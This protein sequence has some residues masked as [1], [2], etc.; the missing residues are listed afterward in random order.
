[1]L[2]L[3]RKRY[4]VRDTDR[5]LKCFEHRL[6][7]GRVANKEAARILISYGKVNA[8]A[9]EQEMSGHRP[10][11]VPSKPGVY[12]NAAHL[13]LGAVSL[14]KLADLPCHII[15]EQWGLLGKVDGHIK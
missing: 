5:N 4:D 8:K 15:A 14:K 2:E 11:V 1:M 12:V 6:V 7:V 10:F 9:L 3:I 13:C